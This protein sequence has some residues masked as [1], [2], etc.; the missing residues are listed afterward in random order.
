MGI[1]D[2]LVALSSELVA[3]DVLG[4]GS[5]DVRARKSGSVG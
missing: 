5:N 3:E 2:K 1:A 4:V